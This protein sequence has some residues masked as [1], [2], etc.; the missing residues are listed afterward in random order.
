MKKKK[1]TVQKEREGEQKRTLK[2]TMV[3]ASDECA[4]MPMMSTARIDSIDFDTDE[5]FHRYLSKN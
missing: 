4:M 5:N 1:K 2:Q 3:E